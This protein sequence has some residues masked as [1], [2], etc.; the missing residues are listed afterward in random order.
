VSRRSRAP[1]AASPQSHDVLS[2]GHGPVDLGFAHDLSELDQTLIRWLQ[3]DGRRSYAQLARDTGMTQNAVR[4]RVGQL[5][6][7]GVV[8]ITAV[9]NPHALGYFSPAIIAVRLD[10]SRTQADIARGVAAHEAVSYVIST[11]G[12]FQ[13]FVE[14][15]C[16]SKSELMATTAALAEHFGPGSHFEVIPYFAVY[17]Q[18]ADF[19][20]AYEGEGSRL[21]GIGGVEAKLGDTDRE[22]IRALSE[23]GRVAFQEI[24]RRLGISEAQVRQRYGRLIESRTLRVMALINPMPLG[25]ETVA[26]LGITVGDDASA[27]AVADELTTLPGVSYLALCAGRFDILA[28]I[29]CYDDAEL[30]RIL[31]DRIHPLEGVTRAEVFLYLQLHHWHVRPPVELQ[32]GA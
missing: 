11:T 18:Q 28:E 9:L 14:V 17:Y 23:D 30:M 2:A 22:I 13:L 24:G 20:A 27:P 12:R 3:V 15:F 19:S 16:R 29:V 4:R 21:T 6:E 32:P 10:A 1:R 31:G 25:F 26:M 5:V 7:E 8:K